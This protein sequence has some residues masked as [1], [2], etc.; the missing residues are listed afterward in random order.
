MSSYYLAKSL[1]AFRDEINARFP[2][3]DKRSD[4]WV[5]DTS[6]SARVSDHNPDW[7]DGG[8]V[9]AIDI[10]VDDNTPTDDLP[11]AVLAAAIG[12][13]RVWY[14]IYNRKIYSRTNGWQARVYTGTN[15]HDKHIHISIRHTS[16]AASD[17]TRWLATKQRWMPPAIDLSVT[18]DQ[19]LAAKAGKK[20]KEAVSIRRLQ[21]SLNVKYGKHLTVDGLAG[22]ATLASYARHEKAVG[23][24]GYAMIPDWKTLTPLV[25][26]LYRVVA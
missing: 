10:D 24:N 19:M 8:I 16:A 6:H 2:K 20:V 13:H 23:Q 1:V 22:K 26:G 3:R 21:R 25:R 15:P 11:K 12:D 17:T 4:G 7:S 5:G 14:V 18:R 9:R